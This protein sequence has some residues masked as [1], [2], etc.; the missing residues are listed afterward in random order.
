MYIYICLFLFMHVCMYV[1]TYVCMYVCMHA[2]MYVCMHVY[3]YIYIYRYHH[4]SKLGAVTPSPLRAV[5]QITI[6]NSS[7]CSHRVSI[8]DISCVPGPSA[9]R[10]ASAC[11]WAR[12][13][14]SSAAFD[15]MRLPIAIS[16]N[17]CSTPK[18]LAKQGGLSCDTCNDSPYSY[19]VKGVDGNFA[20]N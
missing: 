2:C 16:R 9:S 19:S 15:S 10:H 17:R 5:L 11:A 4:E 12:R 3:I 8:L 14:A 7:L 6:R 13:A 1:R 20:P 18:N